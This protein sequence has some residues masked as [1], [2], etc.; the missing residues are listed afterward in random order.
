MRKMQMAIPMHLASQIQVTDQKA[1][2]GHRIK[3]KYLAGA[4]SSTED[5]PK[6]CGNFL[7]SCSSLYRTM[8][9]GNGKPHVFLSLIRMPST[10]NS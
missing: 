10:M 7:R 3:N 2:C 5:D 1:Y 9:M 4:A 6:A 8:S